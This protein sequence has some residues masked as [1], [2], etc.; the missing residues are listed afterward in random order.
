MKKHL[1]K[2]KFRIVFNQI[3]Q[4]LTTDKNVPISLGLWYIEKFKNDDTSKYF[5]LKMIIHYVKDS[6]V[7]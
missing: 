7:C 2:S 5:L 4:F 6:E 1:K 3:K